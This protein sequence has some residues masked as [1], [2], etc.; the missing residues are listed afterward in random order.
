MEILV[1]KTCGLLCCF[2]LLTLT[3]CNRDKKSTG[4]DQEAVVR[5]TVVRFAATQN[6]I[7][8]WKATLP[9]T[10]AIPYTLLVQDALIMVFRAYLD[11][12]VRRGDRTFFEFSGQDDLYLTLEA[13]PEEVQQVLKEGNFGLEEYVV[14]AE[15][16]AVDKPTF[17]LSAENGPDGAEVQFQRPEKFYA[18]GRCVSLLSLYRNREALRVP[19]SIN[20]RLDIVGHQCPFE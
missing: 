9:N 18:R 20:G 17:Q 3:C 10:L 2:L 16:Q 13:T 5:A 4:A 11:D 7:V 14:I 6:A 1:K 8:D 19:E 12:V 15:I